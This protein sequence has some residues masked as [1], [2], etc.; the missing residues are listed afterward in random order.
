MHNIGKDSITV[1]NP[2]PLEDNLDAFEKFKFSNL[3]DRK[4][5]Y[6]DGNLL[7]KIVDVGFEFPSGDI[8]NFQIS[9]S[10]SS[11]LR[12]NKETIAINKVRAMGEDA[13]IVYHR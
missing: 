12:S 7:G 3:T 5:I 2:K 6:E 13:I 9:E 10:K 4:V 8:T 1:N 11:V